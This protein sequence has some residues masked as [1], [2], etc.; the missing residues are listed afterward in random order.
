MSSGFNLHVKYVC[1]HYGLI[2]N[3]ALRV[4]MI[5]Q[6]EQFFLFPSLFKAQATDPSSNQLVTYS[7]DVVYVRV[8]K[9]MGIKIFVPST[10]LLAGMEVRKK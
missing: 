6:I 5:M 2:T 8:V 4:L 7:E 10:R 3:P 9:L 1:I